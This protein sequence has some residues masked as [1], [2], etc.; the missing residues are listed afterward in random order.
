MPFSEREVFFAPSFW[1]ARAYA[2]DGGGEVVRK[3]IE[4]A[5]RFL[6]I[7]DSPESLQAQ[8]DYWE[9]RL[10]EYGRPHPPTLAAIAALKDVA[11]LHQHR[12]AIGLVRS[13]LVAQRD[14]GHPVVYAVRV[15]GSWFGSEWERYSELWKEFESCGGELKCVTAT[16]GPERLVGRVDYPNGTDGTFMP[17]NLTSW[18]AVE[19]IA[20]EQKRH[21]ESTRGCGASGR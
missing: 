19:Q 15:D 6:S 20:T 11:N 21:H 10:K 18:D 4:D 7:C 17:S 3:T 14:A 13:Q 2:T 8:I 1:G 16:I 12:T 9:A 5:E